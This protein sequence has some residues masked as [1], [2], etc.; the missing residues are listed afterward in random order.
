VR[1][2]REPNTITS[3]SDM[4]LSDDGSHKDV[5]ESSS[6]DDAMGALLQHFLAEK[7]HHSLLYLHLAYLFLQ[8]LA[9]PGSITAP[10]ATTL[11]KWQIGSNIDDAS[12]R[13]QK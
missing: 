12:R 4:D 13:L 9:S 1:R 8:Q 3:G 6:E 7:V 5:I 2:Y 10:D 11:R